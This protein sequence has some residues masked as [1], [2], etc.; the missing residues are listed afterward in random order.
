MVKH[1]QQYL[2]FF[3]SVF[4]FRMFFPYHPCM[5]CLPLFT[6]IYLK[7][8]PNVGK[9]T[10]HGWYGYV[11]NVLKALF[12]GSTGQ[13]EAQFLSVAWIDRYL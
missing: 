9:Y 1:Y 12:L 6:Y 4:C 13:I 10:I 7:H 5:V 8:Q 11:F 3:Q 2:R